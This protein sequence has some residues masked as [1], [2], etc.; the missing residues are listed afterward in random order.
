MRAEE[1][2][3]VR[4][5]STSQLPNVGGRS[6]PLVIIVPYRDRLDHLKMFVPHMESFLRDQAFRILVVEQADDKPFN[7]GK[8]CNIGFTLTS[9][10][11]KWIC[12]HDIDMLPVDG[13]CD[14]SPSDRATHLAGCVEQ[15]GFEM[16]YPEYLGGV[17][18]TTRQQF[19]RMNGYSNE[20]WGWGNE[21]D[22]LYIRCQLSGLQIRQ[23]PGRYLSLPHPASQ[24]SVEN[25]ARL[26]RSLAFAASLTTDPGMREEIKHIQAGFSSVPVEDTADY[27]ADGLCELSYRILSRRCLQGTADF[28]HSISDIHEIV[29]VEL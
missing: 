24:C 2:R 8:L 5:I 23:K 18:L 28:T 14:Y 4:T 20:Y 9:P 25:D 19:E 16:P 6:D 15:F 11:D 1:N 7:K 17:F 27:N 29:R 26:A 10:E 13:S 22:D 3:E 21:D 12:F